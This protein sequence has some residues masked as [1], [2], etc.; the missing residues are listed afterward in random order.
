L[1]FV[2][3]G[4]GVVVLG[5]VGCQPT[6]PNCKTDE[7]CKEHNEVC[8]DG[9][10][11]ECAGDQNCKAG[12]VCQEHRCAPKPECVATKDCGPGKACEGGKCVVHECDSDAS[13]AKG[14]R[15]SDH[16]CV[17]SGCTSNEDCAMGLHCES[18]NCVARECNW[19][20]I[21]FEYNQSALTS[22]AVGQ[23]RELGDCLKKAPGK[24]RLEGHADERGTEEYNLQLS[25]RRAASVRKYLTDL[26][27]PATQLSA[28]GYGK[29]RPAVD[30]H[31]EQAWAANRRVEFNRQ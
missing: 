13:C 29:N 6:Y 17:A 7:H 22:S 3:I 5:V 23:L 21:H 18:G 8:V 19:S 16:R 24:V 20:A 1:R 26:G 31:D 10:C 14:S 12:F 15:C 27:V 25:N 2:G 11:R 4:L 30:G 9:Q 28:V